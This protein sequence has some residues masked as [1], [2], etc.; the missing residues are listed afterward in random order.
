MGDY[1]A[2]FNG[3]TRISLDL[4]SQWLD[5]SGGGK[6]DLLNVFSIFTDNNYYSS[7][8]SN[9]QWSTHQDWYDFGLILVHPVII[10][11]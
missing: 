2:S 7:Y 6:P 9:D 8:H 1:A 5:G 11:L 3:K 10:M 4:F